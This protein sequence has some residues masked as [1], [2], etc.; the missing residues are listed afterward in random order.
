MI[1]PNA[2]TYAGTT[3][4]NNGILN[5]QN[6]SALGSVLSQAEQFTVNG[7]AGT[8]TLT[9][10]GQPT[11]ALAFHAPAAQVQTRSDN[12]SSIG[13]VSGSVAVT[14]LGNLYTVAF[15]GSLGQS[16]QPAISGVGT[17][18]T[19]TVFAIL[20]QGGNQDVQRVTIGG[21]TTGTFTLTFNGQ[22][23]TPGEATRPPP[24]CR[25]R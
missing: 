21:A 3:L 1:F 16:T 10:N 19:T 2:N 17:G 13:G 24:R 9:F 18:G 7:T 15:G 14:Q 8:Y 5:V 23:T 12:L 11:S 6:A 22:T 20:T 4:I 25:R